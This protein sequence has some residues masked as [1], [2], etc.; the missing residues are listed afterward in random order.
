M[1]LQN[2]LFHQVRVYV[3]TPDPIPILQL[4]LPM[5]YGKIPLGIL[6]ET[7]CFWECSTEPTMETRLVYSVTVWEAT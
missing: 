4:V 2:F 5:A 7:I 6:S 3:S 1:W